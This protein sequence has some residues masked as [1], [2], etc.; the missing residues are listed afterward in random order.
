MIIVQIAKSHPENRNDNLDHLYRSLSTRFVVAAEHE[1][2]IAR[3]SRLKRKGHWR[4]LRVALLFALVEVDGSGTMVARRWAKQEAA[5]DQ[6][7]GN[8]LRQRHLEVQ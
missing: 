2:Q 8:Q 4:G 6:V 1:L 5:G 3:L 7:A